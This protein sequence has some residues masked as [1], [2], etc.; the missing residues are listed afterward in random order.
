LQNIFTLVSALW[1]AALQVMQN[2]WA[3]VQPVSPTVWLVI[4]T[5]LL[6]LIA[7]PM[8]GAASKKK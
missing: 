7:W 3:W 8:R 6:L 4:I 5:I 1:N 2:F